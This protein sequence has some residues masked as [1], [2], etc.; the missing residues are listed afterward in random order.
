MAL[1]VTE[2][3]RAA[4][5]RRFVGRDEERALF[6]SV[7][8]T[9]EL[10]FQVLYVY[11]PGGVGKTT[12]LREFT[13]LAEQARVP[14]VYV[15][16]RNFDPAPQSFLHALGWKD[17]HPIS[18]PRSVILV[19]TYEILAPLDAWVREIFLPQLD[20][21][22]LLV[23]AG[24][25][26]PA[27]PWRS[28][29]GLQS[30]L[31]VLPLRNLS[32]NESRDYLLKCEVPTD[33]H[34]AVL[35]FTHGHPLA[36]SLVADVFAQRR[37]F[38]FQPEAAPDVI[39][40]LLEQF[41]QKAPGP[42]H[43]AAL[44]ACVLV[45]FTTESLMAELLAMP[46]PATPSAEQGAHELF[47]WLRGLS[48]IQ[49]GPQ[50]IFPHDLAREAMAADIRWRNPDW[51]REL[52]KRA[53]NYYVSH[54]QQTRGSEQQRVL[55]DYIFLH[56][57]NPV[58]RSLFQWQESGTALT[59]AMQDADR[60]TIIEMVTRHEG[61]ESARRAAHWLTRQPQGVLIFREP[62]QPPA[63]FMQMVALDQV[64]PD[65]LKLDPA[66]CTAVEFLKSNAPLR[67]GEVA[68]HFRFWM[69][70]DTYQDPSPIQSL[71]FINIVRHYLTTPR[72][73]FTFIP[74]AHPEFWSAGFAYGDLPRLTA[75]DFEIGGKKYG[76]YGHDW[77]ARP[78]M[79]WLALMAEREV[80]NQ[81]TATAPTPAVQPLIV[82]SRDEFAAAV[83][84][85]LRD[86]AHVETLASNPLLQSRIVVA[87]SGMDA[88]AHAR[89][90]V[91]RTALKQTAESLQASPRDAKFY[92]A[93]QHT[94]L[95]PAPTQEQAAEALD[96]PFSTYR[97]HLKDGIEH[98]VELLW[99][100][101]LGG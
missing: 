30:V 21:D 14:A 99:Q 61:A 18:S 60:E 54:L 13:Q 6:Q 58:V 38:H 32:P 71:I 46:A 36:L 73:A 53:R 100:Q 49:A 77:R 85:A 23:L 74:C 65:D 22:T 25:N 80:G 34:D 16:A 88:P 33:Q 75:A 1:R 76:I 29:P 45:R 66:A 44:E 17:A 40:T 64:T 31:R 78:P 63:G 50:G 101:E 15:D 43:R 3:I 47:D 37:E 7:L 92:R 89:I 4:R 11:G 41:A 59:D 12:L 8:A 96:L 35:D 39:K 93:L 42:A 57:D 56:R 51:Y 26:A 68:T 5:R 91:L 81:A 19:D 10:P 55:T 84:V 27:S 98:V 9:V 83:R 28:D 24:R 2:R 52:H 48:F 97:R 72:L 20:A 69:A 79:Q 87:R 90:E 95:Q 62:N 67:P 94:Y 82:L 86:Y 70:R